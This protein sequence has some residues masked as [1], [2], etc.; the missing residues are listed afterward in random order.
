[1]PERLETPHQDG[2]TL[3]RYIA[4]ELNDL[5]RRRVE[6]HLEA[7]PRCAG[8]LAE[9]RWLDEQLAAHS[10]RVFAAPGGQEALPADDP[11]RARPDPVRRRPSRHGFTS[12]AIAGQCLPASRA[13]AELRDRILAASA[14]D[15]AGLL[16]TMDLSGLQE[17]YAL[18]YALDEAP[19][20]M[21]EGPLRYR[22]LADLTLARLQR[23]ATPAGTTADE[24][25]LSLVD[26]A[27]PPI[28]L[29]ARAHLLDG[30]ICNWTG[31]LDRGKE[32]FRKAWAGFGDG[33]ALDLTF[34]T[35][36]LHEAQRR[37]F[38]GEA[39]AALTLAE[40][41]RATFEE[42]GLHDDA[43][44][45]TY[46]VGLAL[47]YLG[48]EEEA[49]EAFRAAQEVFASLQLWNAYVSS[50]A[51][52]GG[53]LLKL[54]RLAEAKREYARALK[55]T[56][57]GQRPASHAFLRI[58]LAQA[59]FRSGH[60]SEAM[61]AFR[62][63]A[64]LFEKEGLVADG[65]T[66]RLHLVECMARAGNLDAARVHV[67]ELRR[68]LESL[69]MVDPA[70]LRDF[71]AQLSGDQPDFDVVAALRERAEGHLHLRLVRR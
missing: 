30:I 5:D 22:P 47:S 2:Y 56:R 29:A 9:Y 24:D 50:V 69:P 34:A 17:R 70:I 45:A 46:S 52:S 27:Y 43:A 37:A 36:E 68:S 35:V 58:N 18:G 62:A 48:R 49:I 31:E 38:A 14:D 6:R 21:A 4:G 53:S 28:E 20:R 15:L 44:R 41:A 10:E 13:A 11:F 64:R 7:C 66:A 8:D 51:G 1:M 54:G 67:T 57:A 16:E 33:N 39:S 19:R 61:P 63:A 23:E 42:E 40:R 26:F 55:L 3:L 25:D 71:E 12:D 59:L 32:S 65:L 60:Y